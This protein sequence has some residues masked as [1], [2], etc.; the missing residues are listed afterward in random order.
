VDLSRLPED[1]VAALF[2]VVY[3]RGELTP[4]NIRHFHNSEHRRLI[5]LID[6][7]HFDVAAAMPP[8]SSKLC[9]PQPW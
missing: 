6:A 8:P 2:E 5:K 7:M 4:A 1:S 9:R 3:K